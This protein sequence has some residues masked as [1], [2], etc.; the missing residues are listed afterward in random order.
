MWGIIAAWEG[1]VVT[2][3]NVVE[4]EAEA[5]RIVSRLHGDVPSTERIAEMQVIIDDKNASFGKKTWATKEQQPL[6]ADQLAPG[7]YAAELK[8]TAKHLGEHHLRRHWKCNPVAKTVEF[9]DARRKENND[10]L[11]TKHLREKRNDLLKDSDIMVTPDRWAAMTPAKQAAW[12]KYRTALRDL[13]ANTSDVEDI[14][15]PTEPT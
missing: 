9:S 11:L 4:T 2:R 13:P 15:W 10:V 12:T 5:I 14:V 1:D 6:R 7:A 8:V 3:Y